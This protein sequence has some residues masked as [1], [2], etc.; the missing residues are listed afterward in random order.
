MDISR[1]KKGDRIVVRNGAK[2]EQ[3]AVVASASPT[4]SLR[5]HKWL[6]RGQRWTARVTVHPVEVLRYARPEDFRKRGVRACAP[7]NGQVWRG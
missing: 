3:V 5:V 2:G 1:M 7:V 4:P 6:A